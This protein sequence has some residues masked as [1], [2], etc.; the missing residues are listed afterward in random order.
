MKARYRKVVNFVVSP[1][2]IVSVFPISAE[3]VYTSKR[4][5]IIDDII[6]KT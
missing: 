1:C 6:S 5:S 4:H 3:L 2:I